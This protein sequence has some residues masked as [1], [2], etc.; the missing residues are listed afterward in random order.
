MTHQVFLNYLTVESRLTAGLGTSVWIAWRQWDGVSER[1]CSERASR[2][3]VPKLKG[4]GHI[5]RLSARLTTLKDADLAA[6][7]FGFAAH[8][9][10]V[11]EKIGNI[12]GRPPHTKIER[13]I[14][15]F[16]CANDR[17]AGL[18]GRAIVDLVKEAPDGLD[19]ERFWVAFDRA[20][21]T[22]SDFARNRI[23][24]LN[25]YHRSQRPYSA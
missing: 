9:L 22:A 11:V 16:L 20:Q 13:A 10:A 21:Q 15:R 23:E 8:S 3:S 1:A 18:N 7:V 5:G 14:D 24:K 12:R 4:R 17:A 25:R 6:E 2:E 19:D